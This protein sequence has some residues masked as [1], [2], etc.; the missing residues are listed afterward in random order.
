M[1]LEDVAAF[2]EVT[3][4]SFGQYERRT[5]TQEHGTEVHHQGCGHDDQ[6]GFQCPTHKHAN[7][8]G[9]GGGVK[10]TNVTA[11]KWQMYG[12]PNTGRKLILPPPT[13]PTPTPTP[14]PWFALNLQSHPLVYMGQS[15][16]FNKTVHGIPFKGTE[17]KLFFFFTGT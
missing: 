10:K 11:R 17:Q 4:Q 5:G 16:P 1:P 3:H 6:N 12:T 14:P 15:G 7:N 13:P 8:N 9:G 2:K